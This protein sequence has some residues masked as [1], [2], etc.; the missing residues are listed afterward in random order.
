M[1]RNSGLDRR[2]GLAFEPRKSR[3]LGKLRVDILR[4]PGYSLKN[5]FYGRDSF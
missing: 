2:Y 5:N 4:M 1:F 3:W